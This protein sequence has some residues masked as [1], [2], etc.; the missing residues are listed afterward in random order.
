MN[1][2]IPKFL[3][4]FQED[5]ESFYD[6]FNNLD[7]GENV[8]ISGLENAKIK[9][10]LKKFFKYLRLEK[11][12]EEYTKNPEIHVFNLKK[13]IR[14][15]VENSFFQESSSS[16]S[17]ENDEEENND[18][19]EISEKKVL[20]EIPKINEKKTKLEEKP[21]E[22]DELK[23]DAENLLEMSQKKVYG[24]QFISTG[25]KE[26][27]LKDCLPTPTP[28]VE[29]PEREDWLK[30]DNLKNIID[31]SF[32]KLKKSS[33]PQKQVPKYLQSLFDKE[34]DKMKFLQ[35]TE[36]QDEDQEKEMQEQADI[37]EYMEEYDKINN[38]GKSLL[39][40]HKE[41]IKEK[42]KN[43]GG[44]PERKPFNRDTDLQ[45]IRHDSKKIFSLVNDGDNSLSNRFKNSKWEKSF[46]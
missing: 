24:V 8:D 7:D 4:F 37:K 18:L 11:K 23:K 6:I 35:A 32:G 30:D 2:I 1:K 41:K 40:L 3:K 44:I 38:R 31:K 19:K 46:L 27:F 10:Y 33:N 9:K 13:K 22:N 43:R 42:K 29:K 25:E 20:P 15:L 5:L 12:N 39:E 45:V 21:F 17:S 16:S 28:E 34:P 14:D 26:K 36:N